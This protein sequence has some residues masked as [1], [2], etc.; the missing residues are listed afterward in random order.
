MQ[1][2]SVQ[3]KLIHHTFYLECKH[4]FNEYM[5]ISHHNVWVAFHQFIYKV[6]V[7][8]GFASSLLLSSVFILHFL[9]L[10]FLTISVFLLQFCAFYQGLNIFNNLFQSLKPKQRF[11]QCE[12]TVH[13][14]FWCVKATSFISTFTSQM[15]AF[16]T[17]HKNRSVMP[18]LIG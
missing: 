9:D 17:A 15:N 5:V 6:F 10:K 2:V 7:T 14:I 11:L 1:K 3:I 13:T 4:L 12:Q 18:K 16:Q 8:F